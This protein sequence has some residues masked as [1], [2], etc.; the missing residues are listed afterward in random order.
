MNRFRSI[1]RKGLFLILCVIIGFASYF[2]LRTALT[3]QSKI[4]LG[5]ALAY[6]LGSYTAANDST[7]PRSWSEFEN[8]CKNSNRRHWN[9]IDLER[10]F[11]LA[12]GLKLTEANKR[13]LI[14]PIDSDYIPYQEALNETLWR[15]GY[16][17]KQ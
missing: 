12:W 13:V 3:R 7:M 2:W 11:V 1:N 17:S 16:T 14:M 6:D 8:W 9:A 4:T 5:F 15:I 10:Q